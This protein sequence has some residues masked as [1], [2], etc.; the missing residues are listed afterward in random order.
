MS[1]S[2]PYHASLSSQVLELHGSTCASPAAATKLS[3]STK[4]WNFYFQ[5]HFYLSQERSCRCKNCREWEP[6]ITVLGLEINIYS[7]LLKTYI[8]WIKITAGRSEKNN[9]KHL[10]LGTHA[11]TSV[12]KHEKNPILPLAE[13]RVQISMF[14]NPKN[15]VCIYT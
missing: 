3:F 1:T 11:Y 13:N 15:Q 8:A 5:Q 7:I 12:F 14:I 10:C 2:H 6:H 9:M 4:N